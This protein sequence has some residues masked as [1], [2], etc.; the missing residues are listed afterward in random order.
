MNDS[1]VPEAAYQEKWGTVV[2]PN[3]LLAHIENI[4]RTLVLS[5]RKGGQH[6]QNSDTRE[7]YP[8]AQMTATLTEAAGHR[9][10]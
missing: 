5:P 2:Q 8:S 1:E 6:A 4:M 7:T 10:A 3:Y 9:L